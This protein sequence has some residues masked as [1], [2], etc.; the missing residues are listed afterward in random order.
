MRIKPTLPSP[1]LQ[2]PFNNGMIILNLAQPTFTNSKFKHTNNI[3][4]N[5]ISIRK[6][7]FQVSYNITYCRFAV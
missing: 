3:A 1:T 6:S 5:I 4:F 7:C 2:V